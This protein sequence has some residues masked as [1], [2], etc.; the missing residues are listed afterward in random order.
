MAKRPLFTGV[1]WID[2]LDRVIRTAAQTAVALITVNATSWGDVNW[3]EVGGVVG[4]T[5]LLTVLTSIATASVG[6][7]GTAAIVGGG[8]HRPMKHQE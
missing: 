4:L 7:T 6:A 5:A 1:F 2:V 3:N 8:D